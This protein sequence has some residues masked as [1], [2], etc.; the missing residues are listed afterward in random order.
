MCHQ[1]VNAL[2]HL[3]HCIEYME[4]L[5][6]PMVFRFW[7]LPQVNIIITITTIIITTRHVQLE[8]T[9]LQRDWTCKVRCANVL[10]VFWNSPWVCMMCP[11]IT[12][13]VGE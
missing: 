13:T 5:R 7:G 4:G 3:P 2:D 9:V 1:I 10:A 11:C 8:A 12:R 6:H